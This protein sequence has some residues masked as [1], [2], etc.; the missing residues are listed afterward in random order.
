VAGAFNWR[1][2]KGDTVRV[3]E[4]ASGSTTLAAELTPNEMTWSRSTPV[5][6]D[7]VKA[8]FGINMRGTA[9]AAGSGGNVEDVMGS[10]SM[11]KFAIW[12]LALNV[13]PLLFNFGGSL[14]MT[15]IALIALYGPAIYF[16]A[17]GKSPIEGDK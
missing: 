15:I 6:F 14:V 17:K 1:V 3:F 11:R 8:W 13:I 10:R 5:A 7:Q 16:A 2:Q 4:F 12:I 9:P